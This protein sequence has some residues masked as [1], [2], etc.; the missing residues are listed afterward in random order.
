MLIFSVAGLFVGFAVGVTG[1]GGGSLMTPLL[2]LLFGFS[3]AVAVGTDL[4]YAAGT[5]AFGVWLHGR[6]QTIDW[7]IVG[8]LAMGSVPASLATVAWLHF[9]GIDEHVERLMKLTLCVA[10]IATAVLTLIKQRLVSAGKGGQTSAFLEAMHGR[11]QAPITIAG[12]LVLGVLVTM[13]SVGAGVLG[14]TLLL[15]LYPRLSAITIVGTDIAH[16]VPLTL[17]AGIGHI[18]L[19]TPDFMVL[20]YLLLGSLPGIWLGT[21]VGYKLPEHILRAVIAIMLIVIGVVMF[22]DTVSATV[23]S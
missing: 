16:A 6:Q 12:G 9:V 10:I 1:V 3:P 8:R 13:S 18:S 14:T 7:K 11:W 17:I 23:G 22:I 15:L 5:K 21:R 19:G 4:L 2:I 20:F